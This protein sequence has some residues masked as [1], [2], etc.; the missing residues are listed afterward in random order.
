MTEPEWLACRQPR[1]MLDLLRDRGRLSQR[2]ARLFAVAVCRLIWPLL[3]DQRSRRAVEVAE[4]H[5]DDL[6]DDQELAEAYLAPRTA[7]AG[8]VK[9]GPSLCSTSLAGIP[10]RIQNAA[11]TVFPASGPPVRA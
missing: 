3:T 9:G 11:P 4:A 10:F 8:Q 7:C 1:L 2:K 6:A 5:A